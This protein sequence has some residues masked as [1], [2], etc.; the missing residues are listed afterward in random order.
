MTYKLFFFQFQILRILNGEPYI[1]LRDINSGDGDQRLEQTTSILSSLRL[2]SKES[3]I[4]SM[5]F[6]SKGKR[7]TSYRIEPYISLQ[8]INSGYGDQRLEQT[9]SILSSLRLTCK[10]S[11]ISSMGFHSKGKRSEV[12][13]DNINTIIT[14]A[15]L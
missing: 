15:N 14:K 5:G 9:T 13:A 2:T 10:D 1:S 3:G 12:R 7:K 11:G 8:D 4:S 6:H